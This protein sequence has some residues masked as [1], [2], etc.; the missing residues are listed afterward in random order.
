VC[1]DSQWKVITDES[2]D[3]R[4][5][6]KLNS[7]NL[8][9]VIY[10]SGSTGTPKGVLVEHQGLGN[11]AEAQ[12]RAFH[13][14][15]GSRVLQFSS[16]NFD[17]SLFE[18]LMA[19]RSGATLYLGSQDSLLPGPEL[20]RF[21]RDEAITI[22]TL[23]PSALMALPEEG[24]PTLNTIAVAGEECSAELVRQWAA[25]RRLFN[26]YGP[27]ESTIWA[28]LAE[29]T[30][31]TKP[32]IGRP[33][34]NT[35]LYILD[36]HLQPVPVGVPGELHIGGDG[37]ARG[38]LN[39]PELTAR[40]FIG[41]PFR[42]EVGARLYKTGDLARYLA[43]GNIEFLGRIDHQVKIRGY[44]IE[45]GE[46]EVVLRRHDGVKEAV[47]IA[48]E[49]RP[50]D[51]RLVAYVVSRGLEGPSSNELRSHLRQKLPEYMLPSAYVVM[52]KLPL[53][54]NGKVDRRALPAPDLTRLRLEANRVAPRTPVEEILVG[55]WSQVLGI[56]EIGINDN[57]FSDL[58]GHSLVATQLV[59]RV[60]QTFEVD[61]TLRSLFEA[62]TIA[63]MT[64]AMLGQPE[65]R[66]KAETTAQLLLMM[67][68]LSEEE[69]ETMLSER[70]LGAHGGAA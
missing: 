24:L 38:Y 39:Q 32:T 57:F 49:D 50:G 55:I 41:H 68:Q 44:R 1:L 58:G 19:L 4:A 45:L 42:D 66:V 18:C 30:G 16:L 70:R 13:P 54:A 40:K 8:A 17:A 10:T 28:T 64:E 21:L 6:G 51:R 20:A 3:N 61:L 15:P 12:L 69:V 56:G 7:H 2:G 22:V 29:C 62:P 52:D 37:L 25:G 9:Y 65:H 5:N 31:H 33:I 46:I 53:T 48:R 27:T 11:V 35:Q 63:G 60:R 14:G 59:S 36:K 67:N 43:D 47:V 34:A 26:L 23:P